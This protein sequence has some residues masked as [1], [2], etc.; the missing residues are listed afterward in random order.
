M[1]FPLAAALAMILTASATEPSPGFDEGV[2]P[3]EVL[4]A[5]AEARDLPLGERMERISRPMLGKS[6][7]V[8]A[9]G[10]GT[11]PDVDPPPKGLSRRIRR[12]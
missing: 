6:Y 10:E 3:H 1:A 2:V 7:L 5:A 12:H 8:D 11:E 4:Q 9:I